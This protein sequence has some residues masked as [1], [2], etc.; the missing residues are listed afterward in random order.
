LVEGLYIE[1]AK[2][3]GKSL[4]L[5]TR[6]IIKRHFNSARILLRHFHGLNDLKDMKFR[7][8]KLLSALAKADQISLIREILSL[9]P[10]LGWGAFEFGSALLKI[11][12]KGYEDIVIFF[13][14]QV[15]L[16]ELG[17]KEELYINL[18]RKAARVG[19]RNELSI[20]FDEISKDYSLEH[21]ARCC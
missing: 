8:Y 20:M 18:I 5:V 2:Y 3:P 13:L 4:G 16:R 14:K 7:P 17:W 1:A 11:I 9:C 21:L 19:N 15:R 10:T 6:A 12:G